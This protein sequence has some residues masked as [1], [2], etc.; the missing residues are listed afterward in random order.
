MRTRSSKKPKL[1][2]K[3]K[4]SLQGTKVVEHPKDELTQLERRRRAVLLAR[5]YERILSWDDEADTPNKVDGLGISNTGSTETQDG[6]TE[7]SPL[8]TE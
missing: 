7:E 4:Q 8:T 5:I 1:P 3:Q 6:K 2:T